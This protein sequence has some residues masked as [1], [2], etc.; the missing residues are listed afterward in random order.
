[1]M[2]LTFQRHF[3]DAI[4]VIKMVE[5]VSLFI[6][7]YSQIDKRRHRNSHVIRESTDTMYV[8]NQYL[9]LVNRLKSPFQE[10]RL[11]LKKHLQVHPR[12]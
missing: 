11:R 1:M 9:M 10:S 5:W 7:L 8:I 2:C 4:A 12:L 6:F 3:S